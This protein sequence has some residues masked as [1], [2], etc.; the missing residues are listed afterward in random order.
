WSE[1]ENL[2]Y[3]VNT[4]DDDVF[5]VG[6]RDSKRGYY[7]SVREGGLGY[8]DIYKITIPEFVA[9]QPALLPLKLVVK[10]QE[11]GTLKP[12]DAKV[13]LHYAADNATAAIGT[14]LDGAQVFYIRSPKGD[15]YILTAEKSGYQSVSEKITL[16]GAA[17]EEKTVNRTLVL[18]PG[19]DESDANARMAYKLLV[20]LIDARTRK[21]LE[22]SV[23]L[24]NSAGAVAGNPAASGE[25]YEFQVSAKKGEEFRIAVEKSGYVYQNQPVTMDLPVVR[26]TIA[27]SPVAVGSTGI[28]RYLFFDFASAII[29][30]ESIPELRQLENLLL[31]NPT[32]NIEV[33]GHTDDIGSDAINKTLSQKRANAVKA[34]LVKQGIADNRITTV[35]YGE[36]RPLVSNDDEEGGRAINR[37]VAFRVLK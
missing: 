12:L 36:T 15:E 31:S 18:S 26:R 1:P 33:E 11:A 30:D 2:G 6:S 14:E 4:P 20:T 8:L 17:A 29:K 32:I 22:A 35:G 5:F 3:P 13:S 28:M 25:A 23:S 37:R 27:L 7:A 16:E 9:K 34:F 19:K 21:P 10:V 24:L